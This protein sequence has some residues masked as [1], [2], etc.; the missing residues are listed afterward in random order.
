MLKNKRGISLTTMVITVMIMLIIMG[1]LVYSAVDS[2][3]IRKLNK[4]YNDLRQLDDAVGIYYL[5][6]GE[7]PVDTT[8]E[9]IVVNNNDSIDTLNTK[10]IAFVLKNGAT[11]AIKDNFFNPNDFDSTGPNA[12][13]QFLK[14][15]LLDNLTLNYPT[16]EYI[17]NTKSHTIYNFTG[18]TVDKKSYHSLPL[19]YKDT[20]YKES[21]PAT[22]IRLKEDPNLTNV[23][24]NNV[25]LAYSVDSFSLKDLLIFDSSGRDGLGE[26]KTVTFSMNQPSRYFTLNQATGVLT[27]KN[28][29]ADV[30]NLDTSYIS[31]ITVTATNY[32]TASPCTLSLNILSTSINIYD[33]V[34]GG[35]NLEELQ[36]VNLAARQT[37]SIFRNLKTS[38]KEFTV[39][40][41]GAINSLSPNMTVTSDDTD[42]AS[43]T[44]TSSNKKIVFNSGSKSGASNVKIEVVGYGKPSDTIPVNVYDFK[45]SS[46]NDNNI[47][48]LDIA[49]LGDGAKVNLK[50]NIQGPTG[51]SFST[52][53]NNSIQWSLVSTNTGEELPTDSS[54]VVELSG[55]GTEVT[56]TPKKVGKTYLRCIY[57]IENEVL[58][59]SVIPI[60][61]SAIESNDNSQ[62]YNISTDT[63]TLTK[64]VANNP[65]AKLKFTFGDSSLASSATY[66]ATTSSEGFTITSNENTFVAKYTGSSATTGIITIEAT[67]GD[68]KYTDTINIAV[69][70]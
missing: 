2:V 52:N 12:T 6:N 37:A 10:N 21:H 33:E 59:E 46:G 28:D 20:Q 30:E 11:T 25:Y 67:V 8:K 22:S 7:L 26:P 51:Y 24:G 16:N 5:K 36:H 27:R 48:K 70:N 53:E 4:L 54:G 14:L 65:G 49:G 69:T 63:I 39:Q 60:V 31:H 62:I 64:A 19:E 45:F 55:S 40:N 41:N 44:Y 18:V 42:I 34:N 9:S 3:K 57:T 43:A 58:G 35:S 15:N 17:V 13:Y 56:I 68:K 47:N 1:T 66:K 38:S 32:G 50:L 29:G 23:S 61:V